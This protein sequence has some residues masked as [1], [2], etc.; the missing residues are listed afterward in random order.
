VSG[1]AGGSAGAGGSGS[2]SA[3]GNAEGSA[4]ASGSAGAT[5]TIGGCTCAETGSSNDN[6]FDLDDLYDLIGS[7]TTTSAHASFSTSWSWP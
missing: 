4:G 6:D 7:S 5:P 2:G 1:S 3:S